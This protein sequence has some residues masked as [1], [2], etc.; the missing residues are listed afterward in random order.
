METPII[1]VEQLTKHFRIPKQH[2]GFWG[3][4]RNLGRREYLTVRAVDGVSFALGRG[5]LVGYLGPNG[6]GKS[7]TLKMLTGLLVPTGGEIRCN[8]FTP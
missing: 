4:V 6:A 1:Q 5:E 2:G 3:A 7:T 8:G